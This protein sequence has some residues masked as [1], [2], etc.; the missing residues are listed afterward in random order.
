MFVRG[1]GSHSTCTL[2]LRS[3]NLY[4]L[5]SRQNQ[6]YHIIWAQTLIHSSQGPHVCNK[7]LVDS[8]CIKPTRFRCPFECALLERT[9]RW[10]M[11]GPHVDMQTDLQSLH[12]PTCVIRLPL[13]S[14]PIIMVWCIALTCLCAVMYGTLHHAPTEAHGR[15]PILLIATG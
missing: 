8:N 3:P 4:D 14:T 12:T 6:M 11:S 15:A 13:E 7:P 1:V 2:C 10:D 5:V 9:G